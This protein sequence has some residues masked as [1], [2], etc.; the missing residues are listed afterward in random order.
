MNIVSRYVENANLT[1]LLQK[2]RASAAKT[3]KPPFAG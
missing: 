1:P 3:S 2:I